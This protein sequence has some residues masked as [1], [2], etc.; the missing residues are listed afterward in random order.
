MKCLNLSFERF[1][2]GRSLTVACLVAIVAGV[3]A[4]LLA[5][6][7]PGRALEFL[8]SVLE[9][10]GAAWV[11]ALRMVVLPLVVS[12]LVMAVLGTRERAELA[13]M[14]GTAV[15]IFFAIYLGLAILSAILYPPLIRLTGI[16]R[17][18]MTSLRV[19]PAAPPTAA[20]FDLGDGLLQILPTNPFAALAE[21]NILQVVVFTILFALAV[22]RL[23]PA[24]RDTVTAFFSP[25]AEAMLVIV[26]WLLWVSPVTIFA[27]VFAA[28]REIGLGAAWMLVSF[29]IMTTLIMVVATLG[30][31][32]LAGV[33]GRVGTARFARA[34]WPA[35]MV[36]LAT[37]SSLATL[38]ALVQTAKSRLGLPDHVIGF[39]LPFAASTFKPSNLISSPGRLLFLSWIYGIPVDLLGYVVFVGYVMLIS[40]TV[41]G[42]PSQGSR[43][44]SLPAFMALGIP[45]EGI[46]LIG[47]VELLWDF[48]ATVLN[49]TGYLAA[50]SLLPRTAAGAPV[51]SP[52]ALS[53]A[54]S[55]P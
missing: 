55:T 24:A 45:V 40:T 4:G 22:G 29:A 1:S 41:L 54:A 5:P 2:L 14:G 21:D 7:S 12:L 50:T 26:G 9:G 49:T 20:P 31:T 19:E 10:I 6:D 52:P 44:A 39:G 51:S 36:A 33:L 37:R 38:P 46:V 3:I 48:A 35:Q 27:L 17:G 30:L 8:V 18:T 11:R 42:V 53:N 34:A 25:F 47:S 23:A 28:A 15:G 43:L 16:A 13:R 32:P